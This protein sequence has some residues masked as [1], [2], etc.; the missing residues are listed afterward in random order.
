MPP[1]IA[2]RRRS[3]EGLKF[4]FTE[5]SV[6]N[7][8]SIPVNATKESASALQKQHSKHE[9]LNNILSSLLKAVK[10]EDASKHSS[11]PA[12]WKN[13]VCS[14]IICFPP[15]CQQIL[16]VAEN[17]P[18]QVQESQL[19]LDNGFPFLLKNVIQRGWQV[20]RKDPDTIWA[21]CTDMEV[22]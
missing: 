17:I 10:G 16:R 4:T 5:L 9:M 12:S 8:A 19:V 13:Y 1:P 18:N 20:D 6:E 15:S 21:I 11:F 7:A 3:A 22:I 2:A 14:Y